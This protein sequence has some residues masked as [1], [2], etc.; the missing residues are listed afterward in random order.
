ML[1]FTF[2]FARLA[3]LDSDGVPYPLFSYSALVLWT[4]FSGVLVQGG[5]S[6]VANSNLITKVYFPRFAL[7]ASTALS[8]LLDFAVGLSFL[9]VL[10]G[11]YGVRPGWSLLLAPVFLMGLVLFTLGASMFLASLNVWYRDIKHA[12]PFL[13]QLW[14]FV[15]PVIYPITILPRHLQALMAL[16]PLTGIVEGF[17]TCVLGGR[18]LDPMLT[19]ISLTMSVVMF[20]VG[21]VYFRNTERV[22][23]DII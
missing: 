13:I 5:Q 3:G 19:T 22:F 18:P 17:R 14:M 4:Y 8:G 23:A 12:A 7:P 21:L 20:T 16:N 2:F 11:Y 10:M 15:T 9:G 6:L 1:V